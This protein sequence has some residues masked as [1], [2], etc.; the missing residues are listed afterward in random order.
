MSNQQ[1]TPRSG[2]DNDRNAFFAALPKRRAGSGA[3]FVDEARRALLVEPRYKTT[4]EIPGGIV[5][6]GEDPRTTCQRE[7]AEELGID[8]TP[9]RLLVI[10]HKTEPPP[11]G[12]S[13]MFI[14][15][16]GL[17]ADISKLHLQASEL[18]SCRFV[19]A[20]DLATYLSEG[21]ARRLRQALRAL[22][23]GTTVEIVNGHVV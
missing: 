14:Y 10:E 7:C 3:L 17:L 11:H 18:R 15:D 2:S 13:I 16:G 12:D 4:W 1:S 6:T 21:L 20:G 8:L 23:D 22:A 5:E 19:D 9:G